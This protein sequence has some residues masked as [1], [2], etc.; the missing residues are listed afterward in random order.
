MEY[1]TINIVRQI[2]FNYING[3]MI[4][5]FALSRWGWRQCAVAEGVPCIVDTPT[6][7][8]G[9]G[10]AR[11]VALAPGGA[12]CACVPDLDL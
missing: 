7:S 11:L 6:H 5:C 4:R 1:I 2:R 3:N 8:V 9:A 12:G 10:G